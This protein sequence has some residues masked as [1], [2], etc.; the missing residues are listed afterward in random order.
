MTR[1]HGWLLL[2]VVGIAVTVPAQQI[3]GTLTGIVTDSAGA[4]VPGA[5]VTL[6]NEATG[7]VLR[8]R[9]N[10]EGFFSIAGVFSGSYTLRIAAQGFTTLERTGIVFRPGDKRHLSDLQMALGTVTETVTISAAP[11]TLTPLDSAEQSSVITG[12]QL[13]ELSVVGRSAAEFIKVLP[14]MAP[15]GSG[16]V[17]APGYNGEVIGINGNG[18]GGNGRQSALGYFSPNGQRG[19]AMDIVTDGANTADPG[20]N[21]ATPV[22]PNIDMIAE[23]KVMTGTYSAEHSKGPVIINVVTKS[24][25]RDFHGSGYYYIRDSVLN[26]N[27][28]A[29]NR[30][31]RPR[32]DTRY[33]FPGV[34]LGGPVLIPGSNFNRNRDKLFFFTGYEYMYQKID[35]GALQAV[36]PTQA[37]RNGDFSDTA[38]MA[39]LSADAQRPPVREGIV[40]GIIP[41]SL[42]EE[43]G[44]ILMN[45]FP[46]PNA[47][48]ALNSG[49]NYVQSLVY[50]QPM[51]QFASRVDY[52]VSDY[53]KLFV[54]Y[55]LQ[56]E[57]QHFPVTLWGRAGDAVPYPSPVLGKNRSDSISASLTKVFSPTVTN[58]TIFGYTFID[59]PNE[60]IEPEKV[61]RKA[62]GYP[63]EGIYDNG[64]DQIPNVLFAQNL[65]RIFN[66][67]GFNP[68]YPATK[69]LISAA[70]NLSMFQGSHSLK[71]G[72]HWQVIL[73]DQPDSGSSQGQWTFQ[74]TG[75]L[76][77]GNAFAD[78]LM[79]IYRTYFEQ[80]SNLMVSQGYD[81]FE[82]YIQDSWKATRNLTVELGV[83]LSHLQPWGDRSGTG[84]GFAI[85]DESRYSNNP[86]DLAKL[87][88]LVYHGID[89]SIPLSGART[90]ALFVQPRLGLAWDLFGTGR[91]ILRTGFGVFRYN[92]PTCCGAAYNIAA[93]QRSNTQDAPGFMRDIDRLSPR[94]V[95]TGLTVVDL[96]DDTKPVSYN[97]SF[98]LG[99]RLRPDVFFRAAYVGNAGRDLLNG[100]QIRNINKVPYGAMIDNPN[101]PT[102]NFRPMQNYS[103][104][105]RISHGFLS[106]YHSL[107]STL[108]W[109][110]RTVNIQ[111]AYTFSKALG[112]RGVGDQQGDGFSIRNNYGVLGIDRTHMFN[113]AYIY[114]LPDFAKSN[115]FLKGLA[116]GWQISGI[117]T[118]ASGV[119]LSAND[120]TNFG[121]TGFLEDGRTR[122]TNQSVNGTDALA[123][124]P[125]LTCNPLENLAPQQFINGACFAP[126]GRLRNGPITYPYYF[127]GPSLINHDLSVF[128]N[129]RF[130]EGKRLQVR[131]SGYNF[132]NHPL[133]T[134]RAGDTNLDLTFDAAGKLTN[135]STFGYAS[136][137]TGRRVIQLGVKFYF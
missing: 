1:I 71:M 79:G 19:S 127:R 30:A 107:Q 46:L 43:R 27:D 115:A 113:I 72:F 117:T 29:L 120:A 114:E 60:L 25:S 100:G 26:S 47:D 125:F 48:P 23:F 63:I 68:I 87:T 14:G 85:F 118:M 55:N 111:A 10:G 65:S 105:N 88:G 122:I 15:T 18:D 91:T 121:V 128:K 2:L 7:S 37:M 52:N 82:G 95:K 41:R 62:L 70:N 28:W 108:S 35:T 104:I 80:N 53:T 8:S 103:S 67:G 90:R 74:P 12:E 93:G 77:T 78:A 99:Q 36:V 34:N 58:E 32:P 21:C 73:Q 110:T 119:E 112:T 106:N 42:W 9:T 57:K 101:A 16:V 4:V 5:D 69:W 54:R 56:R 136:Q 84:I 123:A 3:T 124:Q 96:N 38:Y 102:D 94:V 86:A 134:F 97:W 24:G 22:N 20:C 129:F 109:Q 39:R 44:R 40:N 130:G 64:V 126:P 51:H 11:D 89:K 75:N 83:R 131:A 59:F 66:R 50:T 132:V 17:N 13:R 6:T 92:E 49:R 135:L 61:S 31:G 98:E 81:T 45:L 133:W 116:N 76:T 33:Q 137:K